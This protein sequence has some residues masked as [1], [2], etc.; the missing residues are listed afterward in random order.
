MQRP[1]GEMGKFVRVG[2]DL[3]VESSA[4]GLNARFLHSY[5]LTFGHEVVTGAEPLFNY[6]RMFRRP[7]LPEYR[8]EVEYLVE[9]ARSIDQTKDGGDNPGLPAGYT[10]LGQFI[11]HDVTFFDPKLNDLL[12]AVNPAV[13]SNLRSPSL[14]LDSVYGLGPELEG[15]HPDGRKIYEADGVYLRVGRTSPDKF[16]AG[17]AEREYENDLPRQPDPSKPRPWMAAIADERNDENLA[18]AQTHL[19]FIKFHNAVVR[20]LSGKVPGAK[21]F[22]AARGTVV[23]HYQWIVLYD[24][25]P[26]IIEKDGLNHV[27]ARGCEHFVLRPGEEPFMPVEFSA[28]AFRF[29]HSLVRD[30]YD[31]NYF[32][33]L[34]NHAASLNDLFS[35]TGF[36]DNSLRGHIN[37]PSS[38]VVDWRRFYDFSGFEGVEPPPQFNF[39]KKIDTSLSRPLL[40][41]STPEG[42]DDKRLR[43][44]PL[45]N[46]LRGRMLGL[47]AGQAVAQRL[48]VKDPLTPD[49]IAGGGG[50]GWDILKRHG[51]DELTPLWFY[52]LKEAE[53]RNHGERLGPVGSR[54]MAETIVGLI[55]RSRVSILPPDEPGGPVWS[56]Y[57]DTHPLVPGTQRFT[58]PDMLYFVHSVFGNYLNP[59][60]AET[61]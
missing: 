35:L 33:S 30:Q 41:L 24:F 51:L 50:A 15:Q 57:Q 12:G 55:K 59:L 43:S 9:L 52:I 36:R 22:E 56:P 2:D 54:I 1:H 46:L 26:R 34:P 37:L 49:E 28:A 48:D 10:Y 44:L 42:S 21:L 47:P 38:W 3:F 27:I 7:S 23:R 45:L 18:T 19:A 13:V 17:G 16:S 6:G 39:S 4:L 8:P 11:D 58:M 40:N 60:S 5:G 53:V 25:L 61:P 31:W 32:Q 14:D 29:G 20:H